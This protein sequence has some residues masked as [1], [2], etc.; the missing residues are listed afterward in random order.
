MPVYDYVLILYPER[1]Q[2]APSA[3]VDS[4]TKLEAAGGVRIGESV[5]IA[6][7]CHIGIGGGPVEFCDY[8]CAASGAKV[9]SGSNDPSALSC[10]AAAPT[11]MQSIKRWTVTIGKYAVLFA[12]AITRASLGE[13]AVLAAGGVALVD[14]PPWEIWGGVPARKIGERKVEHARPA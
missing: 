12:G 10:S 8:S 2:I 1:C 4:F 13:G 11:A 6:S 5:H 7:F 3:R 9:I 14:I